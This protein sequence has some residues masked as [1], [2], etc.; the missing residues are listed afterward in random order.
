MFGPKSSWYGTSMDISIDQEWYDVRCHKQIQTTYVHHINRHNIIIIKTFFDSTDS[1]FAK[2]GDV[3]H[4]K[5]PC[6]QGTRDNIQISKLVTFTLTLKVLC[7]TPNHHAVKAL[8]TTF[9]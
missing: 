4:S 9:K 8:E 1:I 6:R 2:G 3:S 5:S 7:R